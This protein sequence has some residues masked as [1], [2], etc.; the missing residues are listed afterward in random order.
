MGA[1]GPV[2]SG[3]QWMSWISIDD[4]VYLLYFCLC[5]PQ[6]EG[7]INATA[8]HPVPNKTF[9]NILGKALHRPSF[10]PLPA[11][12]VR[13]IFGEMGQALILE[14]AKVIP[15]KAHNLGYTFVHSKLE[16]YFSEVL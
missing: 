4:L 15:Q 9:G 11:F 16:E 8:P 7:P 3:K 1:G 14:G 12:V 2:G 5:N 6:V 13:I 10:I